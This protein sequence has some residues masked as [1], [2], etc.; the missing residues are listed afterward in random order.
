MVLTKLS[1]RLANARRLSRVA[2]LVLVSVLLSACGGSDTGPLVN[3]ERPD[4][5]DRRN[6]D[7]SGNVVPVV[8]EWRED[9]FLSS[10]MFKDRCQSPRLGIDPF[11]DPA[12]PFPDI[13]GTSLDEKYWLRSWSDELYL[14]Y[15]EIIDE[16][17]E[18]YSVLDYFDILKTFEQTPSNQDKDKFHFTAVTS[19]WRASSQ[20]GVSA[21]YGMNLSLLSRQV[22]RDIVVAYTE[23]NSPATAANIRRGAKIISVDGVAVVDGED[24]NTLNAGLFP[25]EINRSVTFEILDVGETNSRF[26]ELSS[27]TITE[28]PVQNISVIPTSTGNVGYMQFNNHNRVAEQQLIDGISVLETGSITDLVLDLRYNGGGFLFIASQLAYMIAGEERT[29]GKVFERLTFN[30]KHTVFDPV[31]GTPLEADPFLSVS[32]QGRALPSLNLSRVFVLTG[33]GTCSASESIINGLRGVDVEVIQIGDTSC[34]KPYGFYAFDNCG[35]TYFSVQFSGE[36][37]KGFG[38]FSDGFSPQ[39]TVGVIG[40]PLP[41]CTVPDDFSRVL[42]DPAEARL[43]AALAYRQDATC[44]TLPSSVLRQKPSP[45]KLIHQAGGEINAPLWRQNGMRVR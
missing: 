20:S 38:D 33:P 31:L 22:P 29:S 30:D 4:P 8:S 40:V 21:G 10:E 26:V 11:S 43:A 35:T 45:R 5:D 7:A 34:G 19:E 1:Q 36:N 24:V 27:Q 28:D 2:S 25:S 6:T 13:E 18:L 15:D 17:P 9:V 44:P 12:A 32:S 42:G 3:D 37:H 39:N 23:P 14:W 41:G 16:D